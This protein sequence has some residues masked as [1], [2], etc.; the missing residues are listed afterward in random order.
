[1]SSLSGSISVLDDNTSIKGDIL[2][3]G[4]LDVSGA[5]NGNINVK[6]LNVKNGGL[7]VGKIIAENIVVAKN[8]KIEGDV[9]ANNIKMLNGSYIKGEMYYNTISIE[10][11]SVIEGNCHYEANE[12]KQN[13][14]ENKKESNK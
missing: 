11:G 3:N 12:E 10:D 14:K 8:G 9:K 13:Y 1:M 7:V 5:I 4:V 6:Q 2:S